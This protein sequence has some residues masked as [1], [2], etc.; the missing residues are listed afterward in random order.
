MVDALHQEKDTEGDDEKVN[1]RLNKIAI[2]DGGRLHLNASGY[3]LGW[4]RDLEVGEVDTADEPA[5]WWHDD[6]VYN[7]AYN[8]AKGSSDDYTDSHVYYVAFHCERFELV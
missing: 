3:L 5:N 1:Q 6:V 7:A 8:L 2:V 4:K